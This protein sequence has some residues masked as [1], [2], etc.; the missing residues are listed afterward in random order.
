[1]YDI[2]YVK[3]AGFNPVTVYGKCNIGEAKSRI[4]PL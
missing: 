3:I 4:W 2:E 1:M